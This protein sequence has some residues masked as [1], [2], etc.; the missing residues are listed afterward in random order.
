MDRDNGVR[1]DSGG[2]VSGTGRATGENWD[3]RT[4]I[5]IRKTKTKNNEDLIG[6]RMEKMGQG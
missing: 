6:R 4:K 3:K 2:W 5:T 1:I